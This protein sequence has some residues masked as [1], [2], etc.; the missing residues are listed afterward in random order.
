MAPSRSTTSQRHR[1]HADRP[2]PWS[3][4]PWLLLGMTFVTAVVL[5]SYQLDPTVPPNDLD[6]Y[7]TPYDD[8]PPER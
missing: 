6:T 8:V 2:R 1:R 4:F 7:R 3:Q 5:A